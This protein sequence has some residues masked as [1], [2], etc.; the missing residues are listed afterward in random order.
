MSAILLDVNQSDTIVIYFRYENDTFYWLHSVVPIE[1]E[2][3]QRHE[4]RGDMRILG[5][6]E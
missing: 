5:G 6:N 2:C 3:L 1:I 4:V